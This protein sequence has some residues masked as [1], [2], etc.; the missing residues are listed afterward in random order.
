MYY[1]NLMEAPTFYTCPVCETKATSSTFVCRGCGYYVHFKCTRFKTYK[2]YM[3]TGAG[4]EEL[5]CDNCEQV[6]F[7]VLRI[8]IGLSLHS[9]KYY[10]C[11]FHQTHRSAARRFDVL[12]E[13]LDN[14]ILVPKKRIWDL[15]IHS[16]LFVRPFA[17]SRSQNP[18][19]GFF[20]FLAQSFMGVR[21]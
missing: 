21:K 10:F 9:K 2:M 11:S 18:F 4:E 15:R 20:Y 12:L 7:L 14:F 6:S 19:I 8:I 16:R 1:S 17:R 13:S 3:N 5:R